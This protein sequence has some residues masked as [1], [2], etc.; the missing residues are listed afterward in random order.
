MSK[1]ALYI[2][3]CLSITAMLF[4]CGS[5]STEDNNDTTTSQ[6]EDTAEDTSSNDSNSSN[7]DAS[8]NKDNNTSNT[9]S[10]NKE[11][12]S[13]SNTSASKSE[14]TSSNSTNNSNDQTTY[15]KVTVSW[16]GD[17]KLQ[18]GDGS[19]SLVQID[20]HSCGYDISGT[21]NGKSVPTYSGTAQF[22]E[23]T[24]KA[25]LTDGS[26]LKFKL[27]DNSVEVSQVKNNETLF[28]GTYILK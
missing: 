18:N 28:Q 7:V 4:G 1:K 19:L 12:S 8:V 27:V 9:A 5:S 25:T 23:N 3:S 16:N 2:I 21:A 11:N 10:T 13:T 20:A 24:A 15:T 14:N 17:F 26:T 6:V 22:N